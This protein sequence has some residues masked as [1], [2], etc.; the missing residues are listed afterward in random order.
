MSNMSNPIMDILKDKG[1][2]IEFLIKSIQDAKSEKDGI[3]KLCESLTRENPNASPENLLK[4]IATSMKVIS[5]QSERI[6]NLSIIALLTVQSPDFD[7][8][9][10]MLLVKMGHGEEALQQMLKNKM[11][12]K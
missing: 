4:C 3:M 9:V 6:Q 10:A 2:I 8:D 7:K 12:G 1:K 11:A 5:R